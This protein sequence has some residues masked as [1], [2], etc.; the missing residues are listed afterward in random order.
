VLPDGA[1]HSCHTGTRTMLI[2][3][4]SRAVEDAV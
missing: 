2:H 4:N 3:S 1:P